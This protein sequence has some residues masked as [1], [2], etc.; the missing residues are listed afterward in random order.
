MASP[1]T[2]TVYYVGQ[3]NVNIA[4]RLTAGALNGGFFNVG[5]IQGISLSIKQQFADVTENNTGYGFLALHAPVSID[6]DIKLQM[7]QWSTR[8]LQAAL[9]AT[10]PVANPS[11]GTVSGE[12]SNAYAGS[13]SY[14][15]NIGVTG[16]VLAIASGSVGSTT[17]TTAGTGYAQATTTITF[18]AAPGG[19]VTATG[20]PIITGGALTGITITNP[21]SGYVTAPA[22]TVTGAGSS[23]AAT[24]TLGG[25]L[26]AGTDYS[27]DGSYGS[28]TA[29]SGGKLA[30]FA[31]GVAIPL[32]ANYT[33]EAT[34][35]S[36]GAFTSAPQEWFV[37]VDAKNVA[38]PFTDSN[39]SAFAAVSFQIYRVM[40]D[41]AKMIDIVS[42]KDQPLELDGK[43]LIDPTVAFVPGNPRS[44][45]FNITKA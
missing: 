12:L 18:A 27:L 14:L 21:G 7:S 31:A 37:R 16:L 9:W 1:S 29:L 6:A 43:V 32:T 36:I 23:A 13:K 22:I 25:A 40:F 11:G 5:D 20:V 3:G 4:P 39:G 30:A 41:A 44:V 34:S 42:K 2:D 35:G 38:N 17:I 24:S 15:Q 26:T 28:Y 19:G 33:Y 45:F 8:N 10:Q